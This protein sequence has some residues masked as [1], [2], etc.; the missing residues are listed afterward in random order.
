MHQLILNTKFTFGDAVQF[1]ST[2]QGLSG[3]GKIFAITIDRENNI[4]YIVEIDQGDYSDL[5]P[6]IYEDEITLDLDSRIQ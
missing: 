6:G 2:A 1:N 5:Q 3:K 4:D